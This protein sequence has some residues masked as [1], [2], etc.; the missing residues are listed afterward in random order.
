MRI[1]NIAAIGAGFLIFGT[2]PALVSAADADTA[3]AAPAEEIGLE[4]IVVTAE[5]RASTVQDTAISI[6]AVSGA[7]LAERGIVDFATLAAE[8]PGISMRDNGP[9]QTEFE[10]RGMTSSGGNSPTVGFYLDDVPMT[11]PA[12]AQNGKVVIDPSLYDLNRAEMLRGPQGTLY[13]SGSMGGTVKLITNQPDPAGFHA[14]GEAVLSD[15]DGGGFNYTVNG[16]LNLPLIDNQMALRLVGTDSHTSGWIDR[17]V[18]SDF[19]LPVASGSQ[20]GWSRGDVLAGTVAHDYTQ[21][22]AEHLAGARGTL[23]WKVSDNFTL[24][25][26]VFY[27]RV[28]QDGPSAYDS[29]PGTM[30]HYQPFDIAEPY[31]DQFT[32]AALTANYTGSGFDLTSVTARWTR[33]STQTQD[34][35]ESFENPFTCITVPDN[36]P[37]YCTAVMPFYGANGVGSGPVVGTETDPSSQFSEELRVASN[38]SGPFNGVAGVFYSDFKSQWQLNTQS[39]N[40]LSYV[41]FSNFSTP[42]ATTTVWGLNE[43]A[44]I[45]QWAIFGEGTWAITPALKETVGARVFSYTS[46]LSMYFAGWGSPLGGATPSTTNVSQSST[47]LDPKLNLSYEFSKDL[48]V[49]ATAAKGFRPGGGN[50]PL[51]NFPSPNA[52][53][54]FG[55]TAWPKTYNADSLWS[56]EVGEKARLLDRRL[57]VNASVYYEDWT[58]IQL[59]E[60]PFGYP[61]FDNA[62]D[63]KIYGGELEINALLGG[64][65][66]LS[67][68]GSYTHA[69]LQAGPHYTI[70]PENEPVGSTPS[71]VLPDVPKD[72]ANVGLD[73]LHALNGPLSLVAHIDYTYTGQRYDLVAINQGQ[74]WSLPGGDH[75]ANLRFGVKSAS[76]WNVALFCTNLGNNHPALENMTALNL[77]NPDFNRVIATQPRTIGIDFSFKH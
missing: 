45:T 61:L 60:L 28:T 34:T 12:Q 2:M 25:P 14:S 56:Y 30:A 29:D 18:L 26:T 36:A 51:P 17:I 33:T 68:S 23:L 4:E 6:T 48:M 10:M 73:Y 38:S 42:A 22:N 32:L 63:A 52:P 41:D 75:L 58:Q 19:P 54:N 50:Q 71:D 53:A 11:S 13:G 46:D 40:N 7:D 55:Y 47:G 77:A 74:N 1:A 39:V 8:T 16:M 59:E 57:I 70:V 35:S 9:G 66:T 24:T 15:T 64:G 43:P 69:T 44:H 21:S 62:G 67:A 27:Q 65:F 5:K 31:S 3:A 76:D 49:Y 37:P 72:T 20:T